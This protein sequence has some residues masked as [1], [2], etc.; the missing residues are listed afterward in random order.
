MYSHSSTV[1]FEK[2]KKENQKKKFEKRLFIAKKTL[3]ED[4]KLVSMA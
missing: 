3:N 1:V 2:R 4:S